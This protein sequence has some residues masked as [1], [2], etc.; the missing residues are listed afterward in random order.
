MPPAIILDIDE[1]VLDN[2]PYQARL[3][4]DHVLFNERTWA[5]WCHEARAMALPGVHDFLQLA[6]NR[7]V[8]VYYI[9]N[10]DRELDASTLANLRAEGLPVG[11]DHVFLGRGSVTPNCV[12]H[13]VLMQFSDQ[14]GDFVDISDNSLHGR[15][16]AVAA[17]RDWFDERW[18]MLPNPTYGSWGPAVFGNDWMQSAEQRRRAKRAAL[19]MD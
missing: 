12:D 4:R 7:G 8:T 14:I 11:G 19:R 1:T 3:I 5:K 2:S 18:F 10:R 15:R 9:S 17:W 13:R 16:D 6:A